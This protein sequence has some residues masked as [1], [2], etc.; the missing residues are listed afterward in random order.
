VN[1][2]VP[3]YIH[4]NRWQRLSLSVIRRR[5]ANIPLGREAS[6]ADVAEAIYFLSMDQAAMI[7]GARLV[8]DGGCLA[9]LY[10]KDVEA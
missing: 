4:S 1:T 10:P 8:V 5:R 2:V 6:P 7:T 9:Q 3:G